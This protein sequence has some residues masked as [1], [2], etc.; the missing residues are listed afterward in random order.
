MYNLI[1]VQDAIKTVPLKDVMDYANGKNP[2]VPSYLAL[3][4]LNRRKQLQD[5]AESF[6]G[7]PGTLKDQIQTSLTRAPEG[8]DPTQT[9]PGQIDITR[10]PPQLAP[11]LAPVQQTAAPQMVNP[12]APPVMAA[13][14][15][16]MRSPDIARGVA[17]IPLSQFKRRNYAGGGIVAFADNEGETVGEAARKRQ[18]EEDRAS[19]LG[20][21]K[22]FGAAAADVLTMPA[23][24]I[25]GAVDTAIIRPAR[26]ITGADIPYIGGEYTESM[27]PFYDKY[28]RGRDPVSRTDLPQASYS[29]EGRAYEKGKGLEAPKDRPLIVPPRDQNEQASATTSGQ[30]EKP[31]P[32]APAVPPRPSVADR[33]GTG[34]PSDDETRAAIERQKM[35]MREFGVS[36]DPYA[37]VRKRYEEI[38]KRRTARREEEPSDRLMATLAA[39]SE[40]APEK[41]LGYQMGQAGKARAAMV[42]E[43]EALKDKQDTE[44]AALYNSMAKEEDARKRGDM[45]AVETELANQKAHKIKI[46]EL[47][48]QSTQAQAQMI[49]AM[50]SRTQAERG[51]QAPA[52]IQLVER[53]AREKGISFTDAYEFLQSAKGVEAL[54]RKADQDWNDSMA[55][56]MEWEKKGGYQAY[57]ASKGISVPGGAPAAGPKAPAPKKGDVVQ[58]Y[59][60]KGGDPSKQDNWEKV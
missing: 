34:V 6:Y 11:S 52:E 18:M 40:A 42:K 50:A 26:A 44:M 7:E 21:L 8:M 23:R 32:A 53:I 16:M 9:P 60:F 25:A 4:E 33:L 57:M 3:A 12:T 41:G 20:G 58:G 28:V 17:S 22:K 24:G 31:A 43:Q 36:Q 46:I 45:K 10:T 13:R 49:N 55:L 30:I 14:G 1:Q 59:R 54:K 51:P 19:I 38:E 39:F 35:L 15:G 29:N 56:R 27:T 2:Q 37:D 47:E 48:N 5:T